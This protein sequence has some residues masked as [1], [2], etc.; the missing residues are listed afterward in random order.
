[1]APGVP[2]PASQPAYFAPLGPGAGD[3]GGSGEGWRKQ[4]GVL[5][6]QWLYGWLPAC[7][8]KGTYGLFP[9]SPRLCLTRSRDVLD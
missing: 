7:E 9:G 8:G 5:C 1:M 6:Q 4:G 2:S 3:E